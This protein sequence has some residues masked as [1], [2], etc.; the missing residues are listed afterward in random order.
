MEPISLFPAPPYPLQYSPPKRDDPQP[1]PLWKTYWM[2]FL[3]Y[4]MQ[5]GRIAVSL[6]IASVVWIVFSL[7]PGVL[8][9]I[10]TFGMLVFVGQYDVKI[11]HTKRD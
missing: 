9:W 11:K 2:I 10:V 3:W 4:M 7:L 8:A 1:P 5:G 6:G